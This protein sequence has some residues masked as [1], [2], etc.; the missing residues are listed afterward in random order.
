MNYV[1]EPVGVDFSIKSTPLT[2]RD[3]LKIS[4]FIKTSKAEQ[5]KVDCLKEKVPKYN[6]K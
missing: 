2:N 3:R 4:V 5:K 1:K 6:P